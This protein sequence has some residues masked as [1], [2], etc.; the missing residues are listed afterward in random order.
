MTMMALCDGGASRSFLTREAAKDLGLEPERVPALEVHGVNSVSVANEACWITLHDRRGSGWKKTVRVMLMPSLGTVGEFDITPEELGQDGQDL[1]DVFPRRRRCN[2]QLI[3][4]QDVL[5][6][7]YTEKPERVIEDYYRLT[8]YPTRFGKVMGGVVLGEHDKDLHENCDALVLQE[9]PGFH[10]VHPARENLLKRGVESRSEMLTMVRDGC[11]EAKMQASLTKHLQKEN[12][13]I[14]KAKLKVQDPVVNIGKKLEAFM[15]YEGLGV[16][17]PGTGLAKDMTPL[18]LHALESIKNSLSFENGKYSVGLTFA[19]DAQ[20]IANNKMM[21]L[22]RLKKLEDSF[23]HTKGKREMYE[24]AMEE[25]IENGDVEE[26]FD[27]GSAGKTFYLPHRAVIREDKTTTK[28]RVVMDGSARAPDGQVLN[29]LLLKGPAGQEDL[30]RI[31]INMRWHRTAIAGDVKKMFLCIGL[32]EED[33][34]YVRFLWA[35]K[36]GGPIKTYRFKC[37]IFGLRDAPF[38]AQ[39]VFKVHARK[40]QAIYPAAVDILLNKRW[41]DDLITSLATGQLAAEVIEQIRTIMAEGGFP[42]KKWVSSDPKVMDSVP[43]E[44]RL[45]LDSVVKL[46]GVQQGEGDVEDDEAKISA[47]G[48]AWF[49]LQDIF[50]IAGSEQPPLKPEVK[51]TK[52]LVASKVAGVFDP[53]GLV[54]PFT[55]GGKRILRRVWFHESEEMKKLGLIGNAMQRAQKLSWDRKVLDEHREQF[56]AWYE[57]INQLKAFKIDRCLVLKDKSVKARQVHMFGDASPFACATAGYCRTEYMDGT[58]S[59]LLITSKSRVAPAEDSGEG[60]GATNLPRLELLAAMMSTRLAKK[61]LEDHPSTEVVYWTDSSVAHQWIKTGVLGKKMWVAN[62]LREILTASTLG[63]WRHVPGVDNP[64]DLATRGIS[65]QEMVESREWKHGPIWLTEDPEQW[66]ARDFVV[67]K[68]EETVCLAEECIP[69]SREQREV[70]LMVMLDGGE[71]LFKHGEMMP[72]GPLARIRQA[73]PDKVALEGITLLFMF[74]QRGHGLPKR[75]PMLLREVLKAHIKDVQ[76]M[77]YGPEIEALEANEEISKRSELARVGPELDEEGLLRANGRLPSASGREPPVILPRHDKLTRMLMEAAHQDCL[78]Q[79]SGWTV[80]YFRKDFWC[81]H[82]TQ[83][84]RSVIGRCVLCQ[85]LRKATLQQ[86]QGQ[87]PPWRADENARPFSYTGVDYAGPIVCF[88]PDPESRKKKSRPMIM[89][90]KLYF[91]VFSCL[92]TRALHLE[93]V[94]SMAT[95]PLNLAVRRFMARKGKPH[96]FFSDNAKSFKKAAQEIEV[97]QEYHSAKGVRKT[98]I[99]EGIQWKFIP[100]RAPHWGG[101]WEKMVG[102]VKSVL[103]V[104]MQGKYTEDEIRTFVAEAEALVNSRPLAPVSGDPGSAMPVTPSELLFGYNITSAPLPQVATQGRM[105]TV[106]KIWARRQHLV[107]ICRRK[108]VRDYIHLLREHKRRPEYVDNQLSEGDLVIFED[109]GGKRCDWPLGRIKK[110]LPGRDGRVRAVILT[111]PGG[112]T[113]RS[114]Q[115]IVPLEITDLEERED[116]DGTAEGESAHSADEERA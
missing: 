106:K 26:V 79:G 39:E 1:A 29:D 62:R 97:L 103:R 48:V 24:K 33:R 28:C 27:E 72:A 5:W 67:A 12:E 47:L 43:E 2:L 116:Q 69:G 41:V 3:L 107:Q 51:V 96:T 8:F 10:Q 31:L 85:R 36:A 45:P 64:G 13:K 6:D 9:R 70:L 91:I 89:D 34:D 92:Q 86:G 7:I 102:L 21:A 16:E 14:E 22:Q 100:E 15:H 57:Q 73:A 53:L 30:L 105:S 37:V 20:P 18:E 23:K 54:T 58:V 115:K 87:L 50:Q 4:G 65:C 44:D 83:V 77:Y 60:G 88:K 80:Y 49:Y 52:R 35:P 66:P 63:Q 81:S 17:P 112:D 110:L 11:I 90:K 111:T 76:A 55:I 46:R 32:N 40:Y 99:A 104:T 109:G 108:F 113:R 59:S 114:V 82:A 71:A 78:H 38:V 61:I 25:F 68:E 19:P 74:K 42:V 101:L 94:D 84:A 93:T 95:E 75:D 56:K 98:L